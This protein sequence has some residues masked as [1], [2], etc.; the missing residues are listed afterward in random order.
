MKMSAN[1]NELLELTLDYIE[2]MVKAGANEHVRKELNRLATFIASGYS[3]GWKKALASVKAFDKGTL[4][5]LSTSGAREAMKSRTEHAIPV[6]ELNIMQ[7]QDMKS[8]RTLMA[9]SEIVKVTLDSDAKLNAVG[10]KS[11]LPVE[12]WSKDSPMYCNVYARY[13]KAGIDLY[14][15]EGQKLDLDGYKG[16][17]NLGQTV[18]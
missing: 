15:R 4:D 9:A 14:N 2:K 7:H 10:V 8:Y 5:I 3:G 18:S 16:C 6:N 13:M 17:I 11:V 1:N 12:F